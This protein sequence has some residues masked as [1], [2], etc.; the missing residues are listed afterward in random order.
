M[1][2][3]S[4]STPISAAISRR[5]RRRARSRSRSYPSPPAPTPACPRA[6]GGR[7]SSSRAAACPRARRARRG[8]RCGRSRP[9]DGRSP[10]SIRCAA[11]LAGS[12]QPRPRPKP[13]PDL[14]ARSRQVEPPRAAFRLRTAARLNNK[15]HWPPPAEAQFVQQRDLTPGGAP[16]D[17]S[18]WPL[19]PAPR[20]AWDD[21]RL[22]TVGGVV[23]TRLSRAAS[24][25]SPL[26]TRLPLPRRRW[27]S[28]RRH[29]RPFAAAGGVRRRHD[30]HLAAKPGPA[31]LVRRAAAAAGK[32]PSLRRPVA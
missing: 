29:L 21:A 26:L 17:D 22:S 4:A 25:H 19:H 1:I 5:T 12:A 27:R 24:P 30:Q 32:L 6:K 16:P 13:R 10:P 20:P 7:A 2:S 15:L 9:T 28:A 23:P 11:C 8:P 3:G 14:A 18:A 31:P